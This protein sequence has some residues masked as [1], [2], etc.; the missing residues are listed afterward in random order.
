MKSPFDLKRSTLIMPNQQNP[1][2]WE[3]IRSPGLA[4][5]ANKI[6]RILEVLPKQWEVYSYKHAR[7]LLWVVFVGGTGTGKSTIFN[8]ICG[9]PLSETGVER[10][11]TFGPIIYA[12]RDAPIRD[13]FP[14]TAVAIKSQSGEDELTVPRSG[15]PGDLLI[16]KH[17]REEMAHLAIVDT[18]DL[19]SLEVR[20][21]AVVEELYLLADG[22][23][24]VTSLEKYA[25]EVPF[26]FLQR[27]NRDGKICFMLLNKAREP[28]KWEDLNVSFKEQGVNFSEDLLWV[29]PYIPSHPSEHL[30]D[31]S[32]F[33]HFLSVF[34][35]ELAKNK[36]PDLLE[37]ERQRRTR[38]LG[39]QVRELT[40]LLKRER[41]E[42]RNWLER[43]EV[44]HKAVCATLLEQQQ[45]HF[46]EESRDYLQ[47]EIRTLFSK[48]DVLRKPRRFVS[49]IILSPLKLL[50]LQVGKRQESHED[51][52]LRI[53]KKLNLEPILAAVG[54]FNRSV[55]ENLS[56]SE[57]S[58]P[59]YRVLREPKIMLND[60]E[61]KAKVWEE[62]EK[63]AVWLEETFKQL[64]QGIPKSK[65]WGIYSTSILWGALILSFETVIGGGITFLEAALDSALA[66]FVTKGAVELF[67]YQE[68]QKIAR[69][70]AKRY[71]EG[72]LSVLHEQRNRYIEGVK[73]LTTPQKTIDDLEEL[74]LS[75][76]S[77]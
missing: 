62:Q 34:F 44:H 8:A 24:F 40:D 69:E 51:A 22:V 1:V 32:S 59:L 41:G 11:K 17:S 52:L 36:M 33:K 26:Q 3:T 21:R 37:R 7:E 31:E 39:D 60:N 16:I 68:L 57:E 77:Q 50:G 4:A 49:S 75:L 23:V 12:H 61:I 58:A 6:N 35:T 45:K 48:Y 9:K 25:D 64:A 42:V 70:L 30:R 38:M 54:K 67:A 15:A 76:T 14:F 73:S 19:D 27:I 47:E 10:P 56:P 74:W 55:L 65:E 18:P 72:V 13:D 5:G 20:N 43:L 2:A 29:L 28:L 53:R 46:N 63:L 66:P 71:R